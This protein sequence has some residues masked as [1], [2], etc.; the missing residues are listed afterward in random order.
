MI[1]YVHGMHLVNGYESTTPTRGCHPPC[2]HAKGNGLRALEQLKDKVSREH[3]RA[4]PTVADAGIATYISAPRGRRAR[5]AGTPRAPRCGAS[6]PR[7][8][9]PPRAPCP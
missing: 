4:V 8:T 2:K 3:G 9:A 7:W 6:G 1:S 5:A